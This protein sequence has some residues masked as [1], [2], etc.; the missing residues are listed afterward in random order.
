MLCCDQDLQ[1]AVHMADVLLGS[2]LCFV[3][4]KCKFR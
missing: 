4:M 1:N 3:V 2:F